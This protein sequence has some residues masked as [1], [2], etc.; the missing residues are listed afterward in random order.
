MKKTALVI[1]ATG[2]IGRA[3]VDEL[4][5]KETIS[6]V[7]T[8]TRRS[9]VI[10]HKKFENQVVDFSQLDQY[11]DYFNNIDVFFSCLGTT[12]QQAGSIA[13]QRVVDLDYQYHAAKLARNVGSNEYFLVSSSAASARSF[14]PYLKMK[15]E[16]EDKVIELGFQRC[17]IFRP[18]LLIGQREQRRAGELLAGKLMRFLDLHLQIWLQGSCLLI[19]N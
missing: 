8:L 13:Q 7:I 2:L 11:Q 5:A 17:V 3:L 15:G 6:R 14:S 10:D 18:S 9:L 19:L 4:L 12:K 16:L 1:G